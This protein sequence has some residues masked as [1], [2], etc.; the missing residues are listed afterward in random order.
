ML[1]TI[2]MTCINCKSGDWYEMRIV[3]PN[4]E[5]AASAKAFGSFWSKYLLYKKRVESILPKKFLES[6]YFVSELLILIR[7]RGFV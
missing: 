3:R 4:I 7:K 6:L 2:F 5:K 1:R